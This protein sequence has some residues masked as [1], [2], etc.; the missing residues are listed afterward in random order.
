MNKNLLKFFFIAVLSF[1]TPGKSNSDDSQYIKLLPGGK[2]RAVLSFLP[3]EKP[4][5]DNSK[6]IKLLPE[7]KIREYCTNNPKEYGSRYLAR[8]IWSASNE[9][10]FNSMP[11][12]EQLAYKWLSRFW[13]YEPSDAKASLLY[14]WKEKDYRLVAIFVFNMTLKMGLPIEQTHKEIAN[15]IETFIKLEKE[16]KKIKA[17]ENYQK[18]TSLPIDEKE[19]L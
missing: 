8:M 9:K 3:L 4:N 19:K 18:K 7:G 11:K 10:E 13:G 2:I 14:N 1:P 6:Y 17:E 12:S 16:A 15:V 5:S